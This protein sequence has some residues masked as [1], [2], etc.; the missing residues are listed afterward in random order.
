M[1]WARGW[2]YAH[3]RLRIRLREAWGW[4]RDLALATHLRQPFDPPEF[5]DLRLLAATAPPLPTEGDTVLILSFRGWSTH[6]V[7]ESV[8][9]HAL[10]QR[11]ARPVFASCGG[12]LP[13]CDIVPAPTAPPMPCRSCAGYVRDAA[14]AAGFPMVNVRDL[15]DLP[16]LLREARRAT[17]Q[18]GTV[19][20]CSGYSFGG[21]PLGELVSTSVKWFVSRGTLTDD[22]PLVL[23]S[24]RRFIESGIVLVRAFEQLLTTTQ[25]QQV[26]LLNGAFFAERILAELADRQ[27]IP[28]VRYEKGF[29]TASVL[30]SRWRRDVDD[31]AVDDA[32]W[33]VAAA[34]PLSPVEQR[35]IDDYLLERIG[36]G[37]TFDN[38]WRE[39]IEDLDHVRTMLR[40]QPDRQT[41]AVLCNILWDSATQGKDDAFASMSEWIVEAIRWAEARPDVDLVVRIHPAEVKMLNHVSREPMAGLIGEAFPRL[42]ANVRVVPPESTLSTYAIMGLSDAVLVYTSTTGLEAACLG[43]PTL[44]AAH[45]HYAGRG[46]TREAANSAAYWA[47]LDQVLTTPP[48]EGDRARSVELARRY[49]HLFFFRFHQHLTSVEE[50]GRS[51]VRLTATATRGL[52]IGHD[53]GLDRIADAV[54]STRGDHGLTGALVT[55]DGPVGPP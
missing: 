31:L 28:V 9:G 35:E 51:R 42:P 38:F 32:V 47:A 37:R 4:T 41:V 21:L 17:D 1:E 10:L 5:A 11:G 54:V 14:A 23:S 48:D 24:Y 12:R 25:P 29:L 3:P 15:V 49:A 22:D 2:S 45:S 53:A 40:L 39:R 55:G 46:F 19:A 6:V 27:G 50:P 33:D 18:L 30:V 16:P 34:Q 8:L 52:T 44:V 36:G 13:I 26:F 43:I 7:I 20:A